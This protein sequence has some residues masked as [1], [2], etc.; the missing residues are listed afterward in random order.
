MSG[1]GGNPPS[2]RDLLG[3]YEK[4]GLGGVDA[5]NTMAKVLNALANSHLPRVTELDVV[6]GST[7]P[8]L[9]EIQQLADRLPFQ[10]TVS[11]N[12]NDMAERMCLADISI[13]AAGGTAWERCCLGLPS[14]LLILAENQLSGASALEKAGAVW[15]LDDRSKIPEGIASLMHSLHYAPAKLANLSQRS[16][17]ITDG[18]GAHIVATFM[19]KSESFDR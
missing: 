18:A 15:L 14:V 12:V 1:D 16:A 13:G 10:S 3:A 7:A 6:I 11:V 17:D 9:K 8:Y 5:D 19:T 2:L 4:S